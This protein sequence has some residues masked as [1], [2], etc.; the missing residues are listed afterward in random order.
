[1]MNQGVTDAD[2]DTV[3]QNMMVQI[4]KDKAKQ[5]G[6]TITASQTARSATPEVSLKKAE[7]RRMM[8]V[9]LIV[10]GIGAVLAGTNF[11]IAGETY[12]VT[13]SILAIG[14]LLFFRGL[15]KML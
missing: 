1:M 11:K 9:G 4:E 7:G 14:A 3:I 10:A 2:A 6:T 12:A 8:L 13:Y 5:A 15:F